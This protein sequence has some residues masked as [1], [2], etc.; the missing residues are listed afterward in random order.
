[1]ARLIT[2]SDE[3][4]RNRVERRFSQAATA[5]DMSEFSHHLRGLV[6]LLGAQGIPLD[7][8]RLA[9]QVFAYQNPER[10]G[11]VRLRWGEEFY[12][13]INRE[14]DNHDEEEKTV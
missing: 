10:V 11:Q 12:T 5:L 8:A 13:A 3:D 7:W 4:S 2:P 9:G 1:M 6:Q 14:K